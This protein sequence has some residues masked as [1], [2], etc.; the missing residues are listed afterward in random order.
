VT[1]IT[2]DLPPLQRRPLRG[3]RV[4]PW[5][6]LQATQ[7]DLPL[8]QARLFGERASLWAKPRV[9]QQL[10]VIRRSQLPTLSSQ[11]SYAPDVSLA[12]VT[13]PDWA[14]DLAQYKLRRIRQHKVEQEFLW[15]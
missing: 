14:T 2:Q 5:E 15:S 10:R 13:R 3:P 7:L 11:L 8:L 1:L 4:Y 6:K 12:P 9:R